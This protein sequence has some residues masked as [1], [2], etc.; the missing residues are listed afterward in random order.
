MSK[1]I[2]VVDDEPDV[3]TY[4]TTLLE[5]AGYSTISASDG[6]EGLEKVRGES[7]DLVTLDIT[8]PEKSGVRMYTEIKQDAAL[9]SIPVIVITG[10]QGEIEKFL[11]TRRQVPP[12]DDFLAKPVDREALVEKVKKLIG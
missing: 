6:E 12:P 5:D 1:K 2:L 9:K 7:P 4:L 8:M 3:V 10:I 11:S